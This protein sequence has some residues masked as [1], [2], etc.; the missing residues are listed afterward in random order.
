MLATLYRWGDI[1]VTT[2]GKY[3]GFVTGP[4]KGDTSLEKPILKMAC[5]IPQW[6]WSELGL[7]GAATAYNMMLL[8]TLLFVGQL[9]PPPGGALKAE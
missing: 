4:G 3:L 2:W 8:S 1:A 7:H 5:R 6:D 9:E